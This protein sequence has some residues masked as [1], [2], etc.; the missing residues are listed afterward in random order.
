LLVACPDWRTNCAGIQAWLWW[1]VELLAFCSIN[2]MSLWRLFFLIFLLVLLLQADTADAQLPVFTRLLQ[3]AK[4]F[5]RQRRREIQQQ[6]A[7]VLAAQAD[8]KAA[9]ASMEQ[10]RQQQGEDANSDQAVQQLR[11]LK[12]VL[13]EQIHQLNEETRKVKALKQQVQQLEAHVALMQQQ[14]ENTVQQQQQQQQQQDP[15]GAAAAAVLNRIAAGLSAAGLQQQQP[16]LPTQQH[17]RSSGLAFTPMPPAQKQ[18]QQP[19]QLPNS[20]G[21]PQRESSLDRVTAALQ[22]AL[23]VAAGLPGAGGSSSALNAGCG[24]GGGSRRLTNGSLSSNFAQPVEKRSV[25]RTLGMDL[26]GSSQLG[27][28]A[29]P[30][31][32]TA[33]AGGSSELEQDGLTPSQVR[34]QCDAAVQHLSF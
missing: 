30:G 6:Q 20:G 17:Q 32:G 3:D 8:W 4:Q 10:R 12:Q 24:S 15:V 22:H 9:L 5:V 11:Q 25:S 27:S 33:L 13:Q 18:V 1:Q 7:A 28:T 16:V 2:H 34:K 19:P 29:A 21:L 31:L 14:H 23:S 26:L